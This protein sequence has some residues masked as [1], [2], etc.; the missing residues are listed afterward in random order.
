MNP[1]APV[2]GGRSSVFPT[3]GA[4]VPGLS[5]GRP[6]PVVLRLLPR[7]PFPP[8]R[9][10]V[11]GPG[12]AEEAEA[13]RARGYTVVRGPDDAAVFVARGFP[14][15]VDA[16]CE[17]GLFRFVA[18]ELRPAWAA[19]VA[20]ALAPGGRLFGGF[21]AGHG[22]A[23]PSDPPPYACSA[24]ELLALVGGAFDADRVDPSA[25]HD[26]LDGAPLVEA[27]FVRR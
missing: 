10:G 24:S 26:P 21:A 15:P 12:A 14:E 3:A 6:S 4:G 7:V 11:A 8:A 16:V 5:G 17:S 23:A 27:V 9:I 2:S 20:E 18:P 25:F 1:S 22:P 19:R 13:L